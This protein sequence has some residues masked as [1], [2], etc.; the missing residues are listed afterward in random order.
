MSL[1]APGMVRGDQEAPAPGLLQSP[2]T[3]YLTV[4]NS[5][6]WDRAL[7]CLA[8]IFSFWTVVAAKLHEQVF[9]NGMPIG[10]AGVFTTIGTGILR[11]QIPYLNLWDHKP[12]GIFLINA[13]LMRFLPSPWSYHIVEVPVSLLAVLLFFRLLTQM[14]PRVPSVVG[15]LV[16]ATFATTPLLDQGGDFTETYVVLPMVAAYALFFAYTNA[17]RRTTGRTGSPWA[18]AGIGACCACAALLK[19]QALLD[20]ALI[21]ACL[22]LR[23]SRRPPDTASSAAWHLA[24]APAA[25]MGVL[26]PVVIWLALRGAG[27]AAWSETVVYNSLYARAV[28]LEQG[29]QLITQAPAG[30]AL[31]VLSALASVV[32]M[33]RVM[34]RGTALDRTA[35]DNSLIV[36]AWWLLGVLYVAAD[37]HFWPHDFLLSVPSACA[38]IALALPGLSGPGSG[39]PIRAQSLVRGMFLPLVG[40]FLACGLLETAWESRDVGSLRVDSVPGTVW[41]LQSTRTQ[42]RAYGLFKVSGMSVSLVASTPSPDETLAEA[43]VSL[44]QP[45]ERVFIWGISSGAYTLSGRQPASRFLYDMPVVDSFG[46][47]QS[48]G[49]NTRIATTELM[50]DLEAY[51][52]RVI[53]V[54]TAGPGTVT[55]IPALRTFLRNTYHLSSLRY[56]HSPGSPL[57]Y[58]FY[59]RVARGG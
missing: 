27:A 54:Q 28:G 38:V 31:W 41:S 6:V 9:R 7:I 42:P 2:P 48:S 44:S 10:D 33:L 45:T 19:P 5:Q 51:P 24:L 18:L 47:V 23:Y 15:T 35:R 17:T 25:C 29:L 57:D 53:A 46:M 37:R 26:A 32:V 56:R 39:L 52:P 21:E 20:L 13:L 40:I 58:S 36:L 1:H 11:G 50:R 12:P 14:L 3:H 8:A 55:P 43:I 34:S 30:I 22:L 16:F 49:Y 59:V 4:G